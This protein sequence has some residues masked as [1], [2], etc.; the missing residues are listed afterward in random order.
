[1]ECINKYN[2]DDEQIAINKKRIKEAF[3]SDLINR[4]YESIRVSQMLWAFNFIR[5]EII[6]IG[7]LQFELYKHIDNDTIVKIHI[8]R[9]D[10]LDINKVIESINLSKTKL[11]EIYNLD[12]IKYICN[13]WLLS[14]KLNEIIS[15]DSNIHKFY[16]LFDVEDG[17][18]CNDDLLNFV[19]QVKDIK[20]YNELEEKTFLQRVIKK[21][22]LNGVIFKMGNGTLKIK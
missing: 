15:D 2:L 10:K 7:R 14:N 13:S 17:E 6:E 8:P 1:M 9:G 12:N 22:L 20:D 4:D 16:E 18:D 5:V 11:K 3:E 21:E 19:Y